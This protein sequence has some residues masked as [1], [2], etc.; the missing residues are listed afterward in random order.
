LRTHC[1]ECHGQGGKA[2]EGFRALDAYTLLCDARSFIVPGR[3]EASELLILVETGVM[4][5]GPRVKVPEKDRQVLRQWVAAGA[6]AFQ[7]E[8]YILRHILEDIRRLPS[9]DRSEVRYLSLN[10]LLAGPDPVH[11]L[12]RQRVRLARGLRQLSGRDDLEPI[13]EAQTVFRLDLRR[14]GWHFRPLT[15]GEEFAPRELRSPNLF[16]LVLLEYP[17]G[18]VPR[19]SEPFRG[20]VKEYLSVAKPVRPFCYLRG[21]WFA[22]RT[23]RSPLVEVL[24]APGVKGEPLP[25]GDGLESSV[26]LVMARAE[27]GACCS[28]TDLR[29]ALQRAG[30]SWDQPHTSVSR[31][32]WERAF[33]EAVRQLNLGLP[34]PP[35]DGLSVGDQ[36]P[37]T[38]FEL[39]VTTNK[40]NNNFRHGEEL[41]LFVSSPRDSFVE[42]IYTDAKGHRF[43]LAPPTAIRANQRQ[44]FDKAYNRKPFKLQG[45]GED[46]ITVY[47]S[48]DTFPTGVR[49]WLEGNEKVA[50][51]IIHA[52]NLKETDRGLALDF[53]PNRLARKT[54]ITL[55]IGP[56]G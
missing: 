41:A 43:I 3:P 2:R 53:D 16:D 5:P 49:W 48:D 42:L 25:E 17:Y 20:L 23:I 56:P 14:H 7:G 44:T 55:R 39:E 11:E 9:T 28:L 37:S 45:P 52:I 12:Q 30:V 35:V 1:F 21:D 34:F 33:P 13:D 18:V 51:R 19:E 27:L 6:P 46:F 10:H 50:H 40:R 36:L 8:D 47:T 24:Q 4:P 31:A 15:A 32:A 22:D 29:A 54:V 38:R 26:S